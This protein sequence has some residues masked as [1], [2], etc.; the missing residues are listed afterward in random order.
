[1]TITVNVEN[2]DDFIKKFNYYLGL[3]LSQEMAVRVPVDK[4]ELKNGIQAEHPSDSEIKI[5]MPM[6]GLWCEYGTD[7]HIIRAKYKKS[8]HWK[9]NGKDFFAKEVHHPGTDPQPFVRPVFHAH[10]QRLVDEAAKL[11]AGN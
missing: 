7:P 6:Q 5:V 2:M 1:M 3:F 8:L 10:L 11:A 9:V 4:G